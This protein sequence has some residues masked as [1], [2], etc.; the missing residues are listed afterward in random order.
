MRR[1]QYQER[2][3]TIDIETDPFLAGRTPEPFAVG[4]K[5]GDIYVD[6]WGDDCI[7]DAVMWLEAIE[8]PLTIYAHNGG[9]FDFMF[10]LA[11]V[12]NPIK[13]IH[14]RIASA[15]LG[16]HTLRDSWLINPQPLSAYKK[17]EIDYSIFE[18]HCRER[19]K[20]RI[21]AYLQGDCSYL[22]EVVIGFAERFGAKLTM[23]GAAMQTLCT[24]HPQERGGRNHDTKFRPW[25][26]GGRVEFFLPKGVHQGDWKVYDVNSMYPHVMRE[27]DHPAGLQYLHI[28][29]AELDNAGWIR[30][31]AGAMYFAKVRG[32]SK[33]AFPKRVED[34]PESGNLHF[35][36]E[37]GEFLTTSHECRAAI[38]LGLFECHSVIE[39]HLPVKRQ[40]FAEFVDKFMADK[41]AAEQC[42]DAIGRLFS[43][44]VLNSGYG[45][46]GQDPDK[47]REYWLERIGIDPR[48]VLWRIPL[49]Y[50]C[51][52]KTNFRGNRPLMHGLPHTMTP[53][54]NVWVTH[55]RTDSEANDK[56]GFYDVAIAA[57]VTS[58]ARAVLMRAIAGA[59]R[60]AYCDT[61]SVICEGL[62]G[63]A[64]DKSR[65]GA[66]K[67]E[68]HGNTL[69][70][71]GKKLYALHKNAEPVKWA[72]KGLR[73][74]P[75][76]VKDAANGAHITWANEAPSF[77]LGGSATFIRR[78]INRPPIARRSKRV[79]QSAT[80]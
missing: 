74:S 57:S 22:Y 79:P 66:W 39:A 31:F 43:K 37:T 50:P 56:R 28:K 62:P 64:L 7:A 10:L 3:A 29:D 18:R 69:A 44:L 1:K 78:E 12:S 71:A 15:K 25:Y 46:F 32:A 11:H 8:T 36:H 6:F 45:K 42:G 2:I 19:H 13:V 38:E 59:T 63:F 65:L 33:G 73:L 14:G 75:E 55:K 30:G 9:K 60:I 4:I 5:W 24:I 48:P 34:G 76:Q 40:R 49:Q 16:I 52:I 67:L 61:D 35:P 17:D 41:L 27:C 20:Q 70:I 77:D 80:A 72:S 26:F 21:L 47:F 23:P 58:A 53:T 68:A 54:H 51:G